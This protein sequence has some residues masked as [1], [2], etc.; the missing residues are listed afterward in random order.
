[1]GTTT[2]QLKKKYN[3]SMLSEASMILGEKFSLMKV[4]GIMTS[5]E[6]VKYRDIATTHEVLKP[7]IPNISP[8][9]VDLTYILFENIDGEEVIFALEYIDTNTIVEVNQ[10]NLRIEILNTS[11]DDIKVLDNALKELGYTKYSI[12]NFE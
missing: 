12:K 5:T 10:V 1:M 4:K 9:L 8:N 2:F 11:T 6:A 7:L 3:F